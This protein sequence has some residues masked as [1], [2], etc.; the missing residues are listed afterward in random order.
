MRPARGAAV[1][2]PWMARAHANV[3]LPRNHQ[4]GVAAAPALTETPTQL[5]TDDASV[6]AEAYREPFPP[7]VVALKTAAIEILATMPPYDAGWQPPAVLQ[8]LKPILHRYGA[9]GHRTGRVGAAANCVRRARGRCNGPPARS[10][11]RP[12]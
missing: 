1:R 12:T 7:G 4:N 9:T 10:R 8:L 3:A 2:L 11:C 6:I 5:P